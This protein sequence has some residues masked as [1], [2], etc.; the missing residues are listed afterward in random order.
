MLACRAALVSRAPQPDMCTCGHERDCHGND[1]A[2]HCG[3]EPCR[4]GGCKRFTAVAP[5]VSRAP[6]PTP[7]PPKCPKCS[8]PMEWTATAP[9][10]DASMEWRC[11]GHVEL[12]RTEAG[13]PVAQ[14]G[15]FPTPAPP[16]SPFTLYK[17][18]RLDE[19][20]EFTEVVRWSDVERH[21]RAVEA[22]HQQAIA[23]LK[24]ELKD[25]TNAAEDWFKLLQESRSDRER[26]ANESW[27]A[28][29]VAHAITTVELEAAEARLH[30]LDADPGGS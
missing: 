24:A 14:G 8:K 26:L 25:V 20:P 9:S 11:F 18:W 12:G 28:E 7:A 13:P 6:Q 23:G 4:R 27:A 22:A 30:A 2:G 3:Q 16:V 15:Q 29:R 17:I 21:L 1:G 10:P 5:A 19:R